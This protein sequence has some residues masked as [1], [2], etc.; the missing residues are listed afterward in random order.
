MKKFLLTIMIVTVMGTLGWG[1]TTDF[2]DGTLEGW[3]DT[4]GSI[5]VSAN[6]NHTPGGMFSMEGI[7]SFTP[8]EADYKETSA[9]TTER[10]WVRGYVFSN[11]ANKV[12]FGWYDNATSGL[13]H[14]VTNINTWVYVA[15]TIKFV[16]S[17]F[18]VDFYAP[19]IGTDAYL[20][21]VAD[22]QIPTSIPEELWKDVYE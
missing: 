22:F 4:Q 1:F 15:D 9:A 10:W 20:D 18:N 13:L 14:S 16:A 7:G 21:D 17:D 2:E 19:G 6:E 11:V 3:V 12:Q 5:N 8:A